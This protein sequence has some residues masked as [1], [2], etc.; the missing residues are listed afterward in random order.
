V[1]VSVVVF[2]LSTAAGAAIAAYILEEGDQGPAG[3]VGPRGERGPEGGPPGPQGE[4]GPRGPRGP[5]GFAGADATV[6]EDS[7]FDAIESDPFRAASAIQPELDPDPAE[8]L[9]ALDDLCFD[10]TFAPALENE[11]L[12]CP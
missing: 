1:L 10:L 3:P 8:V 9:S 6:D 11:F 4:R 5:R 7:V 2:A 12:T